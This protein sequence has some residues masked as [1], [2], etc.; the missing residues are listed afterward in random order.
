MDFDKDNAGAFEKYLF[1]LFYLET[2]DYDENVFESEN[3]TN[4][5]GS[6]LWIF[7]FL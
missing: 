3:M 1:K 4:F 5:L 7:R 6:S 2:F